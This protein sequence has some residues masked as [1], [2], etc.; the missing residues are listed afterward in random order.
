MQTS[1]TPTAF[2]QHANV[3]FIQTT[4]F[5]LLISTA[6]LFKPVWLNYVMIFELPELHNWRRI[7]E[8]GGDRVIHSFDLGD[9]SAA[10]E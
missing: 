9:I 10:G 3:W 4:F 7:C 5:F 2:I 8:L 1:D 6:T